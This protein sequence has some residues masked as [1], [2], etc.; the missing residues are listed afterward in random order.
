V[1]IVGVTVIEVPLPIAVPPQLPVNHLQ[2][3]PVPRLPP[4]TESVVFLPRQIVLVPLIEV[5]GTDVS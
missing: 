1:V 3:A 2:T 4:L 5:A